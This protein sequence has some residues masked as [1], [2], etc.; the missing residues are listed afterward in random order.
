[1]GG[2]A[3]FLALSWLLVHWH[4]APLPEEEKN[5]LG[6]AAIIAALIFM[7][8]QYITGLY[9]KL[10]K[11]LS[12][13]TDEIAF[14]RETLLHGSGKLLT[15]EE[16]IKDLSVRLGK[17]RANQEVAIDHLGLHMDQAWDKIWPVLEQVSKKARLKY[18]LLIFAGD[19]EKREAGVPANLESWL[20]TGQRRKPDIERALLSLRE[21]RR[22]ERARGSIE[23]KVRPYCSLPVVHGFLVG[24]P[25][26]LAYV[27]FPR[28]REKPHEEYFWGGNAYHQVLPGDTDGQIDL[29]TILEAQF[30]RCWKDAE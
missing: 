26:K 16:A 23:P 7:L 14:V 21:A 28:W 17:V 18:R 20:D 30:R 22:S 5:S 2:T 3:L 27:A 19:K 1:M 25:W 6:H 8:S 29:M 9:K 12:E 10:S 15:L 4:I 24:K 13:Q 11:R